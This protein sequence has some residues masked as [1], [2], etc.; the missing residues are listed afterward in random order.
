MCKFCE[1]R[2]DVKFGWDQP[3]FPEINGNI[4]DDSTKV[5]IHDYQT[6][7]PEMIIT[8]PTLG[9]ALW[10]N[11]V[12]TLYIPISFCPVC[13]RKL[14]KEGMVIPRGNFEVFHKLEDE[15]F[16]HI[17][18]RDFHVRN[19]FPILDGLEK[20]QEYYVQDYNEDV[21]DAFAEEGFL[22][23]FTG[24]RQADLFKVKDYDKLQELYSQLIEKYW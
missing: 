10:G 13:G 1:R 4:K 16:I 22:E 20:D 21:I 6:S 2:Q 14:G 15:E 5:V 19:V 18:T 12:A 24:S 7:S 3:K 9:A 8:L 23:R 11:G 17:G